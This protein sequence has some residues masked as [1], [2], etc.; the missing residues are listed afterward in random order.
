M[1]QPS[2]VFTSSIGYVGGPRSGTAMLVVGLLVLAEWRVPNGSV[3]ALKLQHD[4][5]QSAGDGSMRPRLYS[6]P[7]RL[8]SLCHVRQNRPVSVALT[9]VMSYMCVYLS[10]CKMLSP[11]SPVRLYRG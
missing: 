5:F 1:Y 9:L 10:M 6:G 2:C 4:C 11:V 7:L 8:C 3:M